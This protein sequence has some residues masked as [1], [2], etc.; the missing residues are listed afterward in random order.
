[1]YEH[2]S[3]LVPGFTAKYKTDRLVYFEE[4][5]DV[6]VAIAREKQ[7]KGWRREKKV[8]LIEVANPEWSDLGS[9]WWTRADSSSLRSSE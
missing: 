5:S 7:L 4:T 8:R 1:M 3:H 6:Y 2:R 9:S